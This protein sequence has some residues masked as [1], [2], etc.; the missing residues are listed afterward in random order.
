MFSRNIGRYNITKVSQQDDSES[1]P[2]ATERQ[3]LSKKTK[4]LGLFS[5]YIPSAHVHRNGDS[6][7]YNYKCNCK[8]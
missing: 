6:I 7:L 5:S 8:W 2:A 1:N 3:G 4:A